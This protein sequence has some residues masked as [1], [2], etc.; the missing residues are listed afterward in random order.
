M[1]KK[2]DFFA[3]NLLTNGGVG[4]IISKVARNGAIPSKNR[5]KI[6]KKVKKVSQK[7][8]TKGFGCGIISKSP[9]KMATNGH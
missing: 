4:A 1:L 6:S 5:K 8:L 9:R 2:V 3:K 7:V